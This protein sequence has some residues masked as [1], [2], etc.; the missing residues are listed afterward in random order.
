MREILVI[1]PS[2]GNN[3][4]VKKM[5]KKKK[6]QGK[7]GSIAKKAASGIGKTFGSLNFKKALKDVPAIQAGMFGAK[8]AA[9]RFG[10]AASE[11]DPGSWNY[12]SYL[13][14]SVGAVGAALLCNLVRPGMG[15]KSLEGGLNYIIFKALQN[16]VIAG[17]AW[18]SAQFGADDD[19]VPDEYGTPALVGE[20]E[21]GEHFMLGEDANYYPA[22]DS[23]RDMTGILEPVGP[24]GALEPV[25]PLGQSDPFERAWFR[26]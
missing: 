24:L 14:A 6:A 3:R 25:G 1:N 17:N 11:T 20:T 8:W 16:E 10:E 23:Y 21:N 4:K 22:D 5:A 7:K 9:K 13:K 12:A 18:A 26:D 2:K 15:Q 19:Y